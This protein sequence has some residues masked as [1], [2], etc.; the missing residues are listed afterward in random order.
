M[1]T[2]FVRKPLTTNSMRAVLANAE[3]A[4]KGETA[5][6]DTATGLF[7]A[8]KVAAGLLAVGTFTESF[9]GD[10]VR[11]TVV[12]TFDEFRVQEWLNDGVAPILLPAARGGPCYIKD[13]RTVT[14]T[15][16]GHSLAGYVF[17]IDGNGRVMVAVRPFFPT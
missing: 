3:V 12:Q 8:G 4:V 7:V 6:I 13:G 11:V 15:S 17:D 14:A 1:T 5:L 9:T 2:P 10:G 16:L